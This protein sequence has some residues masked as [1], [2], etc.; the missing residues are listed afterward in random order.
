MRIK[1]DAFSPKLIPEDKRTSDVI[2]R[3]SKAVLV[4][5]LNMLEHELAQQIQTPEKSLEELQEDI[6]LVQKN[7]GNLQ[8]P[9]KK[10]KSQLHLKDEL[11]ESD[12]VD[13][14][15]DTEEEKNAKKPK[16]TTTVLKYED[17]DWISF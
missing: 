4:D 15:I 6:E 10:D 5:E 2:K 1:K 16:Y 11:T 17:S 7:L 13:S 12:L 8:L 14:Y 3:D 9:E